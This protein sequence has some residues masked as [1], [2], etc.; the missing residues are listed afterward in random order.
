MTN[1]CRR[2]YEQRIA[3]PKTPDRLR[4]FYQKLL[5]QPDEYGKAR[6][7]TPFAFVYFLDNIEKEHDK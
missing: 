6:G 1:K 5:R 7:E 4:R 3:D 2:I